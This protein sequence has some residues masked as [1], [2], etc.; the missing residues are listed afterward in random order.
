MGTHIAES[1][2]KRKKIEQMLPNTL[3]FFGEYEAYEPI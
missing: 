3:I 1:K 2:E